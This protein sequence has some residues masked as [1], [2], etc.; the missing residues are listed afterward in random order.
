M[1]E[2]IVERGGAVSFRD[3]MELALY[4]PDQGYYS[5]SCPRFGRQGDFLTAPSASR[6][7]CEVVATLLRRVSARLG[8]VTLVDIGSGDGSFLER[9]G[10]AVGG[11]SA[12]VLERMM[13][14]EVAASGRRQQSARFEGAGVP[15]QVVPNVSGLAGLDGPVV[16]HASELYDALPVHRVVAMDDGLRELWVEV[17]DGELCW[18]KRLA[19]SSLEDYFA[20]HGVTLDNGQIA[21]VNL[22]A[23][24][25]HHDVLTT[26][27][28]IGLA[29]LL[30]Y[31]HSASRLYDSR[32]RRGGSIACYREHR[33]SRDPLQH[34]GEQ[35]I[36]AHVNWDDLREA[37]SDIG[38]ATVGLWPLA[39]F[40]VRCGIGEEMAT[41]GYGPEAEIT[42]DVV[43]QRQEVKRLLDPDGMG[44]DLKVLI[45]AKGAMVDVAGELLDVME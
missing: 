41:A 8:P 40:M 7:Y 13:S 16:V 17:A 11:I 35:D 20:R 27:G 45:Q 9:I 21:E 15:V 12:K 29:L 19:H 30:D 24:R 42:A 32:G 23:R 34:P 4:H 33:L 3:F 26:A 2:A 22:G 43:V 38:W 10:V 25:T 28:D 5:R 14:V 18:Q 37:G 39:E 36:T 31:G 44:T 1:A 6:W